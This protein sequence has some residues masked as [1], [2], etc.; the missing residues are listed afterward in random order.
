MNEEFALDPEIAVR[1]A[2]LK[3]L[4]SKF[5]FYEGRFI[6]RFPRGWV[7]LAL[8]GVADPNL[9][10]RIE[11]LLKRAK[12]ECAFLPSGRTYD[13]KRLWIENAVEQHSANPF[14]TVVSVAKRPGVVH[15]DDLDPTSFHGSRDA[16]VTASVENVMSAIRPLL[17]LSGYLVLIDPY[18]RPWATNTKKLLEEVL[19]ES[20]GARCISFTAFVSVKEWLTSLDRA[21]SLMADSLPRSLGGTRDFRVVVCD[22]LGTTSHLHAR[23]L[24]SEKGGV[25]LDKGLQTSPAQ[26]DLSFIDKS[27]HEDL[28]RTF[29]E[30]P[31][32]YQIV[33]Q[34]S[35]RV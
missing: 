8:E 26:V 16:R 20:F 33:R 18:F 22:D 19:T 17:S 2:E 35:R 28:L 9:R 14:N 25:R 27:V 5:G 12:E 32:R 1:I 10:K 7:A 24:F 13:G 31:L 30:R 15:I 4:L 34:F 23:Y 6:S 29:V 11:V 3:L 21:E